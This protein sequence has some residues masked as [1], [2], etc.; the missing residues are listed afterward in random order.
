[1]TQ[2]IKVSELHTFNPFD[3]LHDAADFGEYLRVMLEENDIES[4]QQTIVRA[5]ES[6][7]MVAMA[8]AVGISRETLR[9]GDTAAAQKVCAAFGL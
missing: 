5:A 3:Y 6:E 8:Q 2:K 9:Q 7:K 4:I 1:M